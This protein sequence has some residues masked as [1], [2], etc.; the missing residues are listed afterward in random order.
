MILRIIHS[1][2]G[3]YDVYDKISEQWLFSYVNADNVL[4][5]LA[6]YDSIQVEFIDEISNQKGNFKR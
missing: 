4:L 3:V 1:K 6:R 2:D 5:Q